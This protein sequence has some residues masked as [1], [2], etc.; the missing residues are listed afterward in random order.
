VTLTTTVGALLDR[1][2]R[3]AHLGLHG[4]VYFLASSAGEDA[5]SLTVE[6]DVTHLTAGSIIAVDAELYLVK[7]VSGSSITVVPGALGSTSGAHDVDAIVEVAPRF[8]KAMLLDHLAHEIASWGTQLWRPVT[9]EVEISNDA[10]F[11][12]IEPDDAG[13]ILMLLDVRA[14]PPGTSVANWSADR[15]PQ[16]NA[17]LVRD[18]PEDVIDSGIGLQLTAYHVSNTTL[19]VVYAAG[20]DTTTL[21]PSTDLVDDLGM[22][23]SM[24][25]V[26]EAGTKARALR[27]GVLSRTDYRSSGMSRNAEEVQVLDLIRAAEQAEAMRDRA[28]AREQLELRARWPWRG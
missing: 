8:P 5:T 15:W 22:P 19:R 20:F 10:Q 1:V 26:A 3:D 13:E 21:D 27:D 9:V 18:L 7:S 14:Q 4:P 6:G 12:E 16:V 28:L 17:R 23:A 24:I 25:D 11:Y 2:R